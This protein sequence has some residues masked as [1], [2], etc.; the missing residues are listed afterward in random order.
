M[1]AKLGMKGPG[2][3]LG[4]IAAKSGPTAVRGHYYGVAAAVGKVGAFVG[5]WAFPPMI[6]AFGGADSTRGNTGPF[7]VASG[8]AVFSAI[9]TFFFIRPLS[10]DGMA[11]ED[12]EFR[13]YLEAHGYDTSLMGLG[14]EDSTGSI[15]EDS[16]KAYGGGPDVKEKV[17]DV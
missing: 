12:E 6:D 1:K 11:K 9:I 10:H 5:T 15:E 7:W 2:N 17:H 14:D 13:A 16:V 3:C 4:M 8:L